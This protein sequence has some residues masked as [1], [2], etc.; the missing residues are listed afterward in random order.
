MKRLLFLLLA[1]C[2][3]A[4]A[5]RARAAEVNFSFFF[6]TLSPHGN[7]VEAG[8]YGYCWQPRGVGA[9]WAPYTDGYWVY[10]DAGWTWVSYEDFGSV[11]YHY[12]RWARV[13]GYGWIWKPDYEWAP[14]WVSWRSNDDVIGWAPLPPE[15]TFSVS[16]G[17]GGWV[18][19]DYD[20]G[21]GYYNFCDSRSFG[22]PVMRNVIY[23]R[24]R[25]T[26]YIE[27]TVNITN[28]TYQNDRRW[29]HNGGPDY[30]RVSARSHRRIETL[31][32]DRRTDTGYRHGSRHDL[33][34]AQRTGDRLVVE[35][36][37]IRRGEEGARPARVERK[38]ER[39]NVDRGWSQVSNPTERRRIEEQY[40][41][42]APARR[43]PARPA[44]EESFQ[45]AQREQNRRR[46]A[47]QQRTQAG[48]QQQP[49]S[50]REQPQR[51]P[52]GQSTE[53]EQH[54]RAERE[55]RQRAEQQSRQREQAERS[56][57]ERQQR[58]RAE[59]ENRQRAEQQSRQR[60]QAERSNRERQQRDRSER[61]NR[62]RQERS[63]RNHEKRERS[64]RPQRENKERGDSGNRERKERK[65]KD[66][67]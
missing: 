10:T 52:S 46:E 33:R 38:L 65:K 4:I 64:E 32:L 41:R 5:P 58:D 50:H 16:I 14:A 1:L 60:E 30:R 51:P 44:T 26:V 42:E 18:D 25:N 43:T 37:H 47:E 67:D 2:F 3:L 59:R 62:D 28:I 63:N 29:V 6:D 36:P 54:D 55:N 35:A 56:N 61:E 15:A 39:V 8:P 13:A 48:R 11:T 9:D 21:P 49:P 57:T 40:R 34:R 53:R 27:K 23:P 7:W 19:R 12:G 17:F 31:R 66:R 20:I 22:S 45:T 24:H